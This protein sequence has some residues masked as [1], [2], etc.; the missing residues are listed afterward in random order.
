MF[1]NIGHVIIKVSSVF[2]TLHSVS[3]TCIR[4]L[5]ISE[6]KIKY[7]HSRIRVAYYLFG[8]VNHINVV[9]KIIV[10]NS[11][12]APWLLSKPFISVF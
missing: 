10:H 5:R 2:K 3:N 8:Y 6:S 4:K 11:S 1:S 12:T 9:L 7:F